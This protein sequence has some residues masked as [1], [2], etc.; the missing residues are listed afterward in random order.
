MATN[1][2]NRLEPAYFIVDITGAVDNLSPELYAAA[3]SDTFPTSLALSLGIEE[4]NMRYEEVIRAVS[5]DIQPLQ[6]SAI[7]TTNRTE[8]DPAT[9]IQF[10]LAYDRPEYLHTEDEDNLGTFLTGVD[11]L[12]RY[13]ARGLVEDIVNNRQIYDPETTDDSNAPQ[14]LEVTATALYANV[15]TA[16]G[17]IT[18]NEVADLVD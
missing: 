18:V 2:L 14:I 10:T 7:A 4:T 1:A 6:T 11:A 16:E 9:A 5:T 13:V 15:G 8:D 17:N 12:T 3:N